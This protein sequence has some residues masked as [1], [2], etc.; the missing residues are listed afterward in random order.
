MKIV[1]IVLDS[2]GIGE[3][4]DAKKF[5]DVGSNTYVNTLNKTNLKLNKTN[6]IKTAEVFRSLRQFFILYLS[7]G[8]SRSNRE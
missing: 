3:M 2:F 8:N 6:K 5:G 7:F 1:L 4:P